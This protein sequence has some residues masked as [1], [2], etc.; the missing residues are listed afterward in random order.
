MKIINKVFAIAALTLMAQSAGAVLILDFGTEFSG[1]GGTLS[2]VVRVTI[3]DGGGSGSVDV[4][5]DATALDG[6]FSEYISGLYLNLNPALNPASLGSSS[7]SGDVTWSGL[8]LGADAWQADGD[9]LYDIV[10]DWTN[11]AFVAGMTSSIT[12]SLAGLTE[13]D[14]NYLSAPAGGSGPFVAALRARSL[15]VDGEDS[16]WFYPETTPNDVPEPGT[17]ALLGLGLFGMGMAR[18]KKKA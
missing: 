16:G 2:D 15:G 5:V 8:G 13:E 4:T 10:I 11:N 6:S 3:D 9:G 1:S 14:F 17:L 12:F 18:R 7:G